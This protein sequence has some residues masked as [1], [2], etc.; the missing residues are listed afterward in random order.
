MLHCLLCGKFLL[1]PPPACCGC[2]T[3]ICGPKYFHATHRHTHTNSVEN[4]F[5]VSVF[6]S[7]SHEAKLDAPSTCPLAVTGSPHGRNLTITSGQ[8]EDPGGRSRNLWPPFEGR[9]QPAVVAL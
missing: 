8:E 2:G 6:A 4:F 7:N 1:S 3:K 9:V 5:C